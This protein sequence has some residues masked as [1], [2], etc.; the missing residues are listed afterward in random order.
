MT[1]EEQPR[2]SITKTL[3]FPAGSYIEIK[4]FQEG[5]RTILRT[6]TLPPEP[7]TQEVSIHDDPCP[8]C[9]SSSVLILA[10]WSEP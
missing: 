3:Q 9:G 6:L 1:P 7:A 10:E 2:I 4:C 5:C 8:T